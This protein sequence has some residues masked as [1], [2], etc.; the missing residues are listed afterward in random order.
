MIFCLCSTSAS[1]SYIIDTGEPPQNWDGTSLSPEQQISGYFYLDQDY[2]IQNIEAFIAGSGGVVNMSIYSY[3][4]SGPGSIIYN[5]SF[6]AFLSGIGQPGMWQGLHNL[7][8]NL[9]AGGYWLVLDSQGYNWTPWQSI[10]NPLQLYAY[11]HSGT[12]GEW[13]VTSNPTFATRI[14]GAIASAVPE[15]ATWAM[16]ILGF[17]AIG[18][19][20]RKR[21]SQKARAQFA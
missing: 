5:K 6:D 14:S 15:P 9:A 10:P 19:A 8:W 1:A 16:M 4:I 21:G 17:G 7:N 2:N 11:K 12:G 20:M 13:Q 3:N 18:G